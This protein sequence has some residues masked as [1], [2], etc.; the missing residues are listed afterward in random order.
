M[1]EWLVFF[2]AFCGIVLAGCAGLAY[3]VLRL[4]GVRN[5]VVAGHRSPAPLSWLASPDGAARLHRRLQRAMA[6]A[7]VAMHGRSSDEL[8]LQA[9]VLEL[10]GR[11]LELDQQLVI[12]SR[13]P[14]VARRRM[15]RELHSEIAEVELLVQRTVRMGRAWIG[16]AP[17]ERGLAAVRERLELLETSLR[18]LDGVDVLRRAEPARIERPQA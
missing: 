13:A 12:A 10:Q 11:A 9:I 6:M 17:S 14:R 4:L 2:L 16:S 5:R 1:F 15:L 3:A 8:G 18:E 7:Q